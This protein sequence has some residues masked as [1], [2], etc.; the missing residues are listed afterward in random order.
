MTKK[1]MMIGVT[2]KIRRHISSLRQD[3]PFTTRELITYGSRKAID[4][5]IFRLVEGGEIHRLAWGVFVKIRANGSH[6]K[7]TIEEIAHIKANSFGRKLHTHPF[8]KAK[9]LAVILGL[10][11]PHEKWKGEKVELETTFEISGPSSSFIYEGK[12]IYLKRTTRRKIQLD[13][14][15]VGLLARALWYNGKDAS[16][17]LEVEDNLIRVMAGLHYR[18]RVELNQSAAL[19]PSW[20]NDIINRENEKRYVIRRPMLV[21]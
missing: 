21:A 2:S 12:R 7:F 5:C 20:L 1:N 19:I 13:D 9:E 14:S 18:D 8:K 16:Y 10:V 6:K 17:W 4:N 15:K 3:E 11:R